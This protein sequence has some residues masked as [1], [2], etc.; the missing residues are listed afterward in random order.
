MR[1]LINDH[2]GH[3][4][5]V[6]L[7]RELAKRGHQ[8]V[9]AY[10]SSV[11][12]PH[13]ALEKNQQDPGSFTVMPVGLSNAFKRYGLWSR[14]CQ[15]KELGNKL[16]EIVCRF[17]PDVI[18]SANTPLRAQSDLIAAGRQ[19]KAKFIFWAQDLLGIGITKALNGKMPFAGHLIGKYFQY[20]EKKL[21]ARSD[22]V[23]VISA[24]YMPYLPKPVTSRRKA[25]VIE[26]W[27]PLDEMKPM[28][29][30]NT[31]SKNNRLVDKF[32]YLY[33]G[34]L[35]MKH[36]P[37]LLLTLALRL[38]LSPHSRMVIISEGLGAD[39]LRQKKLEHG[40]DN[41][42]LMGFQPYDVLPEVLGNADVL[43]AVLEPEAGAFAVP[44]KVLTY[45]CT[46][47]AVLLAVPNEN[48]AARIVTDN[49]AGL[50][51]SPNDESGFAEAAIKLANDVDLRRRCA[52]NGL[53]YARENFNITNIANRFEAIIKTV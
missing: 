33:S 46:G 52:K 49:D 43:M 48:L 22:H 23:V 8:V 45:L 41:M 14:W 38:K 35:G 1:I 21:L 31:W 32:C 34:T 40:L 2:A 29:K 51:V 18:I 44:S 10:C 50:V 16:A 7:S 53:K 4:F 3:P 17:Q 13:G 19:H 39:Y 5:Q 30:E 27:A 9:H 37:D 12:T 11:L 36:N 28:P 25:T 6:Q 20:F 26:N 15:E 47:R 24:D 42:V